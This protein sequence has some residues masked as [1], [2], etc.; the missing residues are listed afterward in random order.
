MKSRSGKETN[1]DAK[2]RDVHERSN[3]LAKVVPV[4]QGE[5][6]QT[7]CSAPGLLDA[8]S[9]PLAAANPHGLQ[10]EETLLDNRQRREV[11]SKRCSLAESLQKVLDRWHLMVPEEEQSHGAGVSR[12]GLKWQY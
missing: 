7:V 11:F 3:V 2:H 4:L 12:G 6:A 9:L 1:D 5:T 10:D 8:P